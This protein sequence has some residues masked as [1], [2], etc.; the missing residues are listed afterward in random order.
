M[1]VAENLEEDEEDNKSK[2]EERKI[3]A[4]VSDK[5]SNGTYILKRQFWFDVS[6]E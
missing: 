2:K 5:S 6:G 3:Q 1:T 4:Y